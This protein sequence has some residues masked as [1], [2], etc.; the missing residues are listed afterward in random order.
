M[1]PKLIRLVAEA[2]N[3]E[4]EAL[5][6]RDFEP[7]RR[8]F[9]AHVRA[10]QRRQRAVLWL[11]PLAAAAI[12]IVVTLHS[13]RSPHTLS[14]EVAGRRGESSDW[15]TGNGQ[16]PLDVAFSDG[17]RLGLTARARAQ[18]TE[19][20]ADG[21]SVVL[22][23]GSLKADVVH[24]QQTNWRFSA[25]PFSIRVLGTRFQLEWDP[26][27]ERF[28][29][30]LTEGSVA[31]VGPT[32]YTR[33]VVRAGQRLHIELVAGNAS[34]PC[35]AVEAET[36][37]TVEPEVTDEAVAPPTA[38][39][40][41]PPASW[42]ALA[43]RGEYDGAWAAV[44][45]AGFEQ[46]TQRASAPDLM[47]LADLARYQ[48]KSDAATRVL[49]ELRQRFAGS[50]EASHAA[51]LLGRIAADQQG[52]PAR[53]ADWFAV[54]LAERADGPFAPEALGRLLECQNRAGQL[55]AAR[56]TA[57]TYSQ[58]YPQGAYGALA[59]HVLG[60]S[61]P[62]RDGSASGRGRRP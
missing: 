36:R 25:G 13:F 30:E 49:V 27:R 57:V 42:Q 21:A 62:A 29:L 31:V 26:E 43:A 55:A 14:F 48:R 38:S 53:A 51:F 4:N 47:V 45:A 40:V 22:E 37:A 34:G 20:R 8:R 6:R 56:K 5:R 12:V 11:V 39:V 23:R 10:R 18:V 54:Y 7:R 32:L 52:A 16:A 41:R 17:S 60:T 9:L 2:A 61:A 1:D 24:S 19:L 44:S 59:R 50:A 58:R 33:C 3:A 15:L 46:L 28:A 35:T